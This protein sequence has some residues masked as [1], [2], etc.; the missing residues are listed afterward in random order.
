MGQ[1]SESPQAVNEGKGKGPD[2][3]KDEEPVENGSKEDGKKE[4]GKKE[5]GKKDGRCLTAPRIAEQKTN[6]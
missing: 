6:H 1:E 5:D 4:D 2:A 3:T